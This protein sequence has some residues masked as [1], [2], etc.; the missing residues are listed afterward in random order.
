MEAN[1]S[2]C[3]RHVLAMEGG[4]S[5]DPSDHGLASAVLLLSGYGSETPT[6]L[7]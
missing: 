3:L 2:A 7:R 6:D 4:F 1:F 5:N